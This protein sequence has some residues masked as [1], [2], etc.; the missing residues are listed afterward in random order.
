MPA[1]APTDGGEAPA[2]RQHPVDAHAD[3]AGH[4]RVLRRRAH[5]KPERRVAEEDE[6]Q[7]EHDQRDEHDAELVRAD[8]AGD[9]EAASWGTATGYSLI[10]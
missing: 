1:T 2:Q 10:R 3:Q 9:A 6:Q 4:L 8:D 5:G 7:A